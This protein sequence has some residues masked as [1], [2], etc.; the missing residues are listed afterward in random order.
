[1]STQDLVAQ[2]LAKGGQV[3]KVAPGKTALSLSDSQWRKE[4]SKPGT[5]Q[6]RARDT[7]NAREAKWHRAHDAHFV[8]DHEEGYRIMDEE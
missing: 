1:M 3:E 6:S 7:E 5:V 8:G 2:F 4:V